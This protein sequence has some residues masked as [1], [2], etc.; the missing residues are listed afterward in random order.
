MNIQ[1]IGAGRMGST[2]AYSLFWSSL[3]RSI[4]DRDVIYFWE[5]LEENHKK[6]LA[7]FWD[8]KPVADATGNALIWGKNRYWNLHDNLRNP[9]AFIITAGKPRTD[10]KTSKKALLKTNLPI[11]ER[12]TALIPDRTPIFIVTN[13][14]VEIAR[15][16]RRRGQNAI[17]LRACTDSMRGKK[18]N[19]F[20]LNNKGYTRWT[21]AFAC[22]NEILRVMGNVKM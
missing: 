1:I 18:I 17:P 2:I 9:Q 3:V 22:A 6:A 15:E 10:S 13:P 8:L 5:P 7:E 4:R 12:L 21:P 16:L 14:P 11:V 19:E 20:V